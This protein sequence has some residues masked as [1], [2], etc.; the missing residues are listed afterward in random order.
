MNKKIGQNKI[1]IEVDIPCIN[2]I[3]MIEGR[4]GW[5]IVGTGYGDLWIPHT[6]G[7]ASFTWLP[8]SPS[9]IWYVLCEFRACNELNHLKVYLISC[10]NGSYDR[11][12]SLHFLAIDN[13][14]CLY[15][16]FALSRRQAILIKYIGYRLWRGQCIWYSGN[17]TGIYSRITPTPCLFYTLALHGNQHD[18]PLSPLVTSSIIKC[19]HISCTVIVNVCMIGL[20]I[21][22]YYYYS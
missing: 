21:K 1:W 19:C 17:E 15:S 8:F 3:L 9:T 7:H 2:V 11:R 10:Y 12:N 22:Y 6:K 13:N 20:E 4:A 14:S 18:E 5:D 16:H